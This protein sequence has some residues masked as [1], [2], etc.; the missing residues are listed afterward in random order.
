M[1]VTS[2]VTVVPPDA[3]ARGAPALGAAL[4]LGSAFRARVD[5][6]WCQVDGP[7]AQGPDPSAAAAAILAQAEQAGVSCAVLDPQAD[8]RDAAEVLAG[9][10]RVADIGVIEALPRPGPGARLIRDA[11]VFGSGRPVIVVG[12]NAVSSAPRRVLL[13]WDDSPAAARAMAAAL[14]LMGLAAE[15][16]VV[17]VTGDRTGQTEPASDPTLYLDRH[18]I[19]ATLR[20]VPR[21]KG[22]VF[23][24]LGAAAAGFDLLVC[25]AVRRSRAQDILFGGVT[26]SVLDGAIDMSVMLMA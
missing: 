18:G 24:D 19:D 13:A 2:I 4:A 16:V 15:V 21:G 8:A 17:R 6:I 10:L 20:E 23:A 1:A 9:H 5:V 3:M 14:P 12:R 25:G 22:E 26:G 11:A 7:T